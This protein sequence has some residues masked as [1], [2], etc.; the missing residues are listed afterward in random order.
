MNA[1]ARL[2]KFLGRSPVVGV[3]AGVVVLSY[4]LAFVQRPGR[5]YTD[6]RLELTLDPVRFLHSV[7]SMWSSTGDLGHVQSGQFV[8][9]LVPMAPWYA[10]AHTIGLPT[11]VA[12]RIWMGTLLAA[13]GLGVIMLLR[14]WLGRRS[15][16][17]AQSVAA[18]LFLANPY[19]VVV[20][21]RTSVWLVTYA[22]LPWLLLATH[23]GI[24]NSRR[25][26]WPA[27]VGLLL[28]LANGGANAALPF[29]IVLALPAL[30]VYEVLVVREVS[31]RAAGAFAWR[32]AACSLV[33]SLW[34]LIPVLL[35]S[36][37]SSN[38]LPFTEQPVGI[39][40]TPSVSES[41]RLL[42]FWLAYFGTGGGPSVAAAG[43]YLFNPAVIVASFLVPLGAIAGFA[44]ARRWTYGP[45]LMLLACAAVITMSLGFPPGSPLNRAFIAVYYHSTAVQVLRTTWKA[46]P[47]LALP[48]ACLAGLF[49]DLVV[50]RAR[51]AGELRVWRLHLPAWSLVALVSVPVLWALPLFDGSAIDSPDAYGSVPSY[52]RAAMHGATTATSTNQRIMILPGELFGWYRWGATGDSSIAPYLTPR[53]VTIREIARFSD[54]H[55]SQLQTTIDDLVGQD[56]LVPGQ[57]QPLL[58]LLGVGAVLVPTDG[59]LGGDGSRDPADV[60]NALRDQRPFKTPAQ[61]YGESRTYTPAPGRDGGPVSLPDIRRY[62]L[63]STSPGVVRV[64]PVANTTILDG[65]GSGITELAAEHMLDPRH[66]LVYAGDVNR[67][68]ISQLVASGAQ[69]AFTDSNR[70][71]ILAASSLTANVGPT[72][73]AGD[74]I[75]PNTPSYDLF[76]TRG[77]EGMTVAQYSGLRYLRTPALQPS[78]TIFPEDAPYA[79]LDGNLNTAWLADPQ[80]ATSDR[81]IDLALS[82]P[83]PVRSIRIY[84]LWEPLAITTQVAISVN[85]GP[86]RLASLSRG[87]NT[88]PIDAQPLRTLRI[89]ITGE[90]GLSSAGGISELQIP[91]VHVREA[92]RLPTDLATATRGLDLSHSKVSILLARTT[93]DFPYREE[94]PRGTL[95]Q[96]SV[97]YAADAERGIRRVVTLPAAR[98]FTVWRVGER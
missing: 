45:F 60:A 59:N 46:A 76:P 69:L 86:E 35:Q 75:A 28:V 44:W 73:E 89:R 88:V 20:I 54:L 6:T 42:G 66:A 65:D 92:L 11:W 62:A 13:A 27:V 33:T 64:S 37:Y 39:L 22:A 51:A 31:W 87:W 12:E 85:G 8:G 7:A 79:A 9:Y 30:I 95:Q 15:A 36:R 98:S 29:W 67:R 84:P 5:V 25:W 53:R 83:R 74:A 49:T 50:R 82:S 18:V 24:R 58:E 55:S 78:T 10:F 4:A 96:R 17:V 43:P 97:V 47:L 38:P 2:V 94:A 48:I 71:Q 34:W 90:L 3:S 70:R 61:S 81:Y 72:L 21:G 32:A 63:P 77:T 23:R 80:P 41:L 93:A 56:R 68:T 19:V 52:W 40:S 16:P 1:G 14:E 26:R 91:G 57:L